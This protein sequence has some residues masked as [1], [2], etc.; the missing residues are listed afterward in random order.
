MDAAESAGAHE[1]NAD[2]TRGGERTAHGGG[3]DRALHCARGEVARTDLAGVGREALELVLPEADA[4]ATVEDADGRRHGARPAHAPLALEADLDAV[5]RREAVRDERRLER[6]DGPPFGERGRDL[7]GDL[8][9]G[10]HRGRA[11]R[12]RSLSPAAT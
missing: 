2:R 1:A 10:G 5:R 11:Y 9:Q 6:D 4:D 7:V 12:R 8:Q 3:A